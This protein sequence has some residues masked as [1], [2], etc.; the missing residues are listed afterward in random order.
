MKIIPVALTVVLALA[1]CAVPPAVE[2]QQAAKM[3]RVGVL[4]GGGAGCGS[5]S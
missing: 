3:P 5:R 2:A 1:D 4:A